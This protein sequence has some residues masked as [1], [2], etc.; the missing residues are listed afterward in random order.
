MSM[1]ELFR[2]RGPDGDWLVAPARV[3]LARAMRES[4]TES[5]S[6]ATE[7]GL[8]ET[9]RAVAAT[10]EA[11]RETRAATPWSSVPSAAAGADRALTRQAGHSA[12]ERVLE[13][14]RRGSP[15]PEPDQ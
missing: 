6:P 14:T 7:T 9:I 11:E 4:E 12:V 2:V 10:L 5:P 13:K 8:C 3:Q 15:P 1:I